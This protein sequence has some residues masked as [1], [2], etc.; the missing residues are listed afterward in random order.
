MLQPVQEIT[1]FDQ[2]FVKDRTF[3]IYLKK[4]AQLDLSWMT[5]ERYVSFEDENKQHCIQAL[6]IILRHGNAQRCTTVRCL[7]LLCF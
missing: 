5:Y 3:K 6:D 2:E 4:V 7:I 1:V